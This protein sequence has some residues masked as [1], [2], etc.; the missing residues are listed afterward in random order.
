MAP[1][2][3]LIRLVRPSESPELMLEDAALVRRARDGS[4][5]AQDEL[6]RRHAP[7]LLPMLVHLLACTADAEDALQ[8]AFMDALRDLEHLREDDA[9]GGWLR[10]IAVRKAHRRF[11]KR[12]LLAALGL[13]RP[14]DRATFEKL[15]AIATPP[16]V[17]MEL[18]RLDA[19][20]ERMPA[21][22]RFAWTLRYVEGYD[23]IDVADACGCSLAT[24]KRRIAGAHARVMRRLDLPEVDGD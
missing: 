12:R 6:F 16:E 24:A 23:L 14:A 19:V 1:R 15:A 11:R 21:R 17:R 8:D 5:A 9:F 13:D 18:A 4:L 22:L 2:E 7:L 10:R 3:S 20:L